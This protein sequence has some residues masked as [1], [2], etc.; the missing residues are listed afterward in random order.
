MP[1]VFDAVNLLTIIA[2]HRSKQALDRLDGI[3]GVAYPYQFTKGDVLRGSL[4][5]VLNSG[6]QNPPLYRLICSADS[7]GLTDGNET[8]YAQATAI[9]QLGGDTDPHIGFWLTVDSTALDAALAAASGNSI[10]AVIEAHLTGITSL[11]GG[12]APQSED[13]I[14]QPCTIYKSALGFAPGPPPPMSG[15]RWEYHNEIVALLTS[16]ATPALDGLVTADTYAVGTVI[17]IIIPV[18][19]SL[20]RQ[21]WI[22]QAGAAAG[23]GQVAPLD[24]N[25][26]TNDCHWLKV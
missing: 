23:D 8:V 13:V 18:E 7:I 5:F 3:A 1:S 11:D 12:L 20:E 19:G 15:V 14:R 16:D 9:E 22:L 21:T 10:P 26:S 25:S 6:I 2:E 24:Y 17:E 4:Y